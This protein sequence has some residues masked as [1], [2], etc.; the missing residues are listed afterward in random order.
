MAGN[1]PDMKTTSALLCGA[2]LAA[3]A[4]AACGGGGNSNNVN[5]PVV[6]CVLPTGTQVALAY[7]ISGA[8][9]VPDAPGQIA[10]AASP[11]LPSNWQVVLGFSN[12]L[13]FESVVNPISASSVPTPYATPGFANPTYESSGLSG[14]LPSATAIAVL[15][16]N[17]ASSCNSYL[18]IGTFTTQ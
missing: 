13:L 2:M 9:G 11:A 18:Q 7:P 15:L 16:N 4:L 12:E 8:T 10:I 17:E 3:C 14:P 5:V 1:I 6:A